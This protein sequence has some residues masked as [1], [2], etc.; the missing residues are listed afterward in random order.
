MLAAC[1]S[2]ST[3]VLMAFLIG[4]LIGGFFV[5]AVVS[6]EKAEEEEE[7]DKTE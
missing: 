5:A 6:E 2:N 7:E 1:S 4:I 3:E